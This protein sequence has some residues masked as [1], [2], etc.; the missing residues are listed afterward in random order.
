MTKS[1][2]KTKLT[3]A[4]RARAAKLRPAKIP[5]TPMDAA[6]D[7]PFDDAEAGPDVLF[8]PPST[9]PVD[10]L[11]STN[12]SPAS[13]GI[14]DKTTS[15]APDKTTKL[16]RLITLL[17]RPQGTSLVELC[18]ATGWQAHSVRGA[19][20]GTLKHKG[21]AITSEKINGIRRYCIAASAAAS[22]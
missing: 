11:A 4:T 1:S 20:A 14:L 19:L 15:V 21:H 5:V 2:I 17:Q 18:T 12:N 9:M 8:A 7:V 16:E 3:V 6:L 10:D 22:A 13:P